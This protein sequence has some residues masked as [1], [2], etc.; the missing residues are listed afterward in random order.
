VFIGL[1]TVG[2]N[3]FFIAYLRYGYMG[4]FY[5]MAISQFILQFSYWYPLNRIL[6]ITPIYNFKWRFIKKQLSVSLP[7][8][9]HYYS[10]YLLTTSDRLVMKLSDISTGNI[11]MYNA[12]NTVSNF[13]AIIANASGQAVGPMLLKAYKDKNEDLARNLVFVLQLVFLCGTFIVSIW[14]KEIFT[15]L[16]KNKDLQTVYPLGVILIMA[17]NYRPMYFGANARLFYIEKT[18]SLL[19]VSFIAGLGTFITNLILMRYVGY[20]IAAFTT[21][22]GFMYMGY[23]GYFL[24]VYKENESLNYFPVLWLIVTIILTITAYFAVELPILYKVVLT[25]LSVVIGGIGL[26]KMNKN[27]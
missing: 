27:G 1:L 11:G 18:K 26:K 8:V 6:K 20:E 4:W 2:L 17:Y 13:M 21:F 16:L 24:K 19:K 10:T 3:V 23:S 25:I 12:A 14:L 7:T 5:S 9:P 15:F 22:A